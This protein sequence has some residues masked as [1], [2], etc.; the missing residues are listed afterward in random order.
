MGWKDT[1]RRNVSVCRI[2]LYLYGDSHARFGF[3]GLSIPFKDYHHPSITMH[4][5]GRD[6]QIINFYSNEHTPNSIICVVYGEVDCRCHIQKQINLGR[7]EDTIIQD[8]VAA[9]IKTI[10][11]TVKIYKKIILVG[12]IPPTS[13][14]QVNANNPE[15]PFVGTDTDR[16]RHTAKV[17]TLL[18]HYCNT[19]GYIY[20][21]PYE[22]YTR[23][24]GTLNPILS[25]GS[26][27][28]GDNRVFLQKFMELLQPFS[29]QKKLRMVGGRLTLR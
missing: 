8:L 4:R 29:V 2:M 5:I 1:E 26:V 27:H 10:R 23:E 11:N 14:K 24:D 25:D 17:N 18:Q 16:V 9:Y 7:N 20:F 12:V 13:E 21:N 22:Y 3:N 28:I 19:Y 6:N 15:F